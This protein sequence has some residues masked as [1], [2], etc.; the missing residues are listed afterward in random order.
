[1]PENVKL[2]NATDEAI[3]VPRL[4]PWRLNQIFDLPKEMAL[5]QHVRP[6]ILGDTLKIV[7]G[8]KKKGWL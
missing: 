3:F 7:G 8:N 1:V 6:R 5:T 2:V 4:E